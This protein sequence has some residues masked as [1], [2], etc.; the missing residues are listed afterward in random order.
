MIDACEGTD[1]EFAVLSVD[2]DGLKEV[3]DV[4]GHAIGDK[5]LIEVARLLQSL[6]RGGVVA[7]LSGDEFGL[8]IDGTQ[9]AAGVALAEQ[10][11]EALANEFQ[12]DGKS[13]RTGVTTGI[14]VFPRNGADAASLLVNA[15]AALFRAKAA[16]H[17]S[18]SIYD[19]EMDE[20][21]RDRRV[22]HQDL[23]L[24]IKNG[25]LSLHYQPQAVSRQTA[26]SSEV[27]GFEALARWHHPLARLRAARR[28]HSAR[29]RKRLDRRNGGMDPARSLPGG[30]V[31]ADAAADRCQPVAGAVHA[32]RYGQP[33]AFDT[34]RNRPHA[35]PA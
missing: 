28:V 19:P 7:R 4:F 27:I 20:Q 2:L 24:A 16:S 30:R 9:P 12:I 35:G 33:V 15:G 25:E 21:I 22:L 14:S 18:I 29:G 13:V 8:I 32:R 6:V 23:S 26:A 11:A 34:S 10:L 17:G 31:A 3:N 5:L 1:E